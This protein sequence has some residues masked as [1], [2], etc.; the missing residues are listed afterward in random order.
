MD[1]TSSP[2]SHNS[3]AQ[4][5]EMIEGVKKKG[6]FA[7]PSRY[8]LYDLEIFNPRLFDSV[9]RVNGPWSDVRK[10]ASRLTQ[11]TSLSRTGNLLQS[12]EL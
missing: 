4:A 12:F 2:E 6:A 5:R 1:P 7:R 3:N 11:V 9:L 8:Q 10:L